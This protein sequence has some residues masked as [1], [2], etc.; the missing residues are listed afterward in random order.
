MILKQYTQRCKHSIKD[1]TVSVSLMDLADNLESKA[2]WLM[3]H[4][5]SQEWINGG[6]AEGW[7]NA[8]MTITA[9][10]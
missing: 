6:E 8:I 3:K 10:P 7:F 5:R 1:R 9:S 4:L 2:D